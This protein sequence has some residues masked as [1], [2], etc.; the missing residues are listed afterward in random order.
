M[1]QAEGVRPGD[2][3]IGEELDEQRLVVLGKWSQV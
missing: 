1:C 2:P 3:S